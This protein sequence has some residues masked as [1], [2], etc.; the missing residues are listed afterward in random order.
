M[1][2]IN[3]YINIYE[4]IIC[5]IIK[6]AQKYFKFTHLQYEINFY[7]KNESIYK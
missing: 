1:K 6:N 7:M 3:S 5:K 4:T 2:E